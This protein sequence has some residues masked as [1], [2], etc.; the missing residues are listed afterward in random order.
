MCEHT[1]ASCT[2]FVEVTDELSQQIKGL[3]RSTDSRIT[4]LPDGTPSPLAILLGDTI[5][6]LTVGGYRGCEPN[7]VLKRPIILSGSACA[8]ED[9]FNPKN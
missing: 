4:G 9:R 1:C 5:Q 3:S 6:P 8:H 2:E 7:R